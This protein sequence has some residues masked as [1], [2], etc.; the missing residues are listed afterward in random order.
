MVFG[1]SLVFFLVLFNTLA[2][3]RAQRPEI[4]DALRVMGATPPRS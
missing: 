2:G 3:V 4:L 1:L